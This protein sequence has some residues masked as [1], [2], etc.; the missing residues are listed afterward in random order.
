MEVE[1]VAGSLLQL[2]PRLGWAMRQ[3]ILRPANGEVTFAQFRILALLKH[4]GP[5]GNRQLAELQGVD[6]ASASRLVDSLVRKG[7]ILRRRDEQDR[8]QVRVQLSDQGGQWFERLY[9]AARDAF[10]RRLE[11]LSAAEQEHLAS[12]L[13]ALERIFTC[14]G[15]DSSCQK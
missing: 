3:E 7:M 11:T 9:F 15:V 6:E 8:R 13:V 5:V 1:Q 4:L 14:K 10:A 2:M 12:A